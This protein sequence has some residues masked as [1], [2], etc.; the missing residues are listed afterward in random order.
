MELKDFLLWK[1]KMENNCIIE[2]EVLNH[3]AV[4]Q[5]VIGEVRDAIKFFCGADIEVF[6]ITDCGFKIGLPSYL[7]YQIGT[8]ASDLRGAV[9]GISVV[10]VGKFTGFS[11]VG[12]ASGFCGFE[13]DEPTVTDP[14]NQEIERWLKEGVMVTGSSWSSDDKKDK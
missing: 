6:D 4:V 2:I 3:D 10:A 7:D 9:E 14:D 1:F 13:D 11:D 12:E 8:I 5:G